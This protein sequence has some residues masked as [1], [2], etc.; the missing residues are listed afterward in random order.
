MIFL[1]KPDWKIMQNI[2]SVAKKK[3]CKL[4]AFLCQKFHWSFSYARL[5]VKLYHKGVGY[6]LFLISTFCTPHVLHCVAHL[7]SLCSFLYQLKML[8][9]S[10]YCIARK[11][12]TCS[13]TFSYTFNIEEF[14]P[15]EI[16]PSGL[17]LTW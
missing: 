16:L 11:V 5:G 9:L 12:F 4:L 7:R 17:C 1:Y 13:A 14:V 3:Y 10:F 2:F 6:D 15:I 8:T